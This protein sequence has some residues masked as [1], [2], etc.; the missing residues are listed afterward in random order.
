MAVDDPLPL[1]WLEAARDDRFRQIDFLAKHNPKEAIRIGDAIADAAT[2]LEADPDIARVGRIA[3]TRELAVP[4]TPFILFYRIEQDA[5]V[6]K[7]GRRCYELLRAAYIKTRYSPHYRIEDD[8]LDWLT[9]RI[10][11][12]QAL[13]EIICSE[14]LAK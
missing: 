12:L 8:E 3:G 13:T 4:G 2:R 11:E 1:F 10:K 5:V 6:T 14:R 9:E 7:F